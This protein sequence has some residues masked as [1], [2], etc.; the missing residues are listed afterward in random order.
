[1]EQTQLSRS[2][3][4]R[5]RT[6]LAFFLVL[7]GLLVLTAWNL[8]RSVALA[9]ATQA[10]S[11]GDL[12]ICLGHAL[13]H[14][15]RQPWS[16]EAAL[17]AARCLSRLDFTEQAEPYFR[18]AGYLTQTDL[19]LRAYGLARGPH[20]ELAIPAFNEILAR[21]PDNL[22]ALRRLAAV[23]LARNNMHELLELAERI[24]GTSGGA[25][26]GHTLRGVTYHNDQNPQQAV[27]AFE[28]VLQLDPDLR[29]MPLPHRLF[30]SY[31]TGDL[32]ES[33]RIDDASRYLTKAVANTPDADL[34][35][36]LGRIYFFQGAL[37]DAERCFHQAAEWAPSDYHPHL[38]LAKLA[39]QRRDREEALKHLSKA[40]VL[41]PRQYDVLYSLASVYRQLGLTAEADR[42]QETVKQLRDTSLSPSSS[43]TVNSPW[44]RY[45]L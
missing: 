26:L 8:T 40:N 29:D 39:L 25:V 36:Q 20:P 9:Q 16:R 38:D 2:R 44:P 22:T 21:W 34:M 19:Q 4:K 45:A 37:D 18:R 30:W 12:A 31:L 35:T 43:S 15:Q 28:H 17:W 33:G 14:L 3:S 13:D 5:W 23:Q 27:I 7:I 42:V 11:R 41:E 10:Y 6:T 1:M 24:S 32:I